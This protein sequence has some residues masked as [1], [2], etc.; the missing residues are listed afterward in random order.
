M[1]WVRLLALS[2]IHA[3]MLFA[4]FLDRKSPAQC[5]R[6]LLISNLSSS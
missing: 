5:F 2:D 4:W 1:I 3:A 6:E